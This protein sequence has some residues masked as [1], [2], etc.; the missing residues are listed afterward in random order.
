MTKAIP[1]RAIDTLHRA[2]EQ[3]AHLRRG[4]AENWLAHED[5]TR[6]YGT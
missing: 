5:A 4:L 3:V 6:L 2:R 1:A